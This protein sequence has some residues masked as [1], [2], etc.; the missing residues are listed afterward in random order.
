MGLLPGKDIL[1]GFRD[2]LLGKVFNSLINKYVKLIN[3]VRT[4]CKLAP[5]K[6]TTDIF[7]NSDLRLITTLKSFDFPLEPMPDNFFYTGPIMNEPDWV[8]TWSSPWKEHDERPL[9]VIS[10]STTYQNQAPAI[11][12][13]IDAL[14]GM[15]ARGLVTLG[16]AIE[17]EEFRVPDNVI[18]VKSAPH[19]QI[20]PMADLVITHAGHGTLMRALQHGVPLICMPMGRDQDD[21]AEKVNYHGCGLKLK[22][23]SNSG[24]VNNAIH[25]ILMDKRFKRNAQIFQ[26][27][28]K[29]K[30]F[31]QEMIEKIEYLSVPHNQKVEQSSN[32]ERA[33]TFQFSGG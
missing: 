23:G 3:E 5:I 27:Q 8:E 21:N 11:Q 16:P 9:I 2:R 6:N 19:S 20:F 31:Q 1:G 18:V 24:K 7:Y 22:P 29:N 30:S 14:N 25:K 4:Q 13:A 33:A 32:P 10:L 15:N 17:E 26:E 12:A 28:L